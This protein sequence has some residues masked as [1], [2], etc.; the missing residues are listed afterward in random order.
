MPARQPKC[1]RD[2]EGEWADVDFESGLIERCK[3]GWNT[4][5]SE[6]TNELLATYLRQRIAL[7]VV[8]PE[9]EKRLSEGFVDDTE[10]YEDELLNAIN[11]AKGEQ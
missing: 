11:H 3:E 6:L 7:V 5:I 10:L 8:L 2:I 1:V 4:P 9:A